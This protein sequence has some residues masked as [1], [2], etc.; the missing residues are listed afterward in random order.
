[1][2]P[3]LDYALY[4]EA[5]YFADQ[6]GVFEIVDSGDTHGRAMRQ[7]CECD[8]IVCSLCLSLYTFNIIMCGLLLSLNCTYISV[9]SISVY[10]HLLIVVEYSH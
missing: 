5:K 4:D 8:T 6:T 1:M 10:I 2:V 9:D 7:V 3:L